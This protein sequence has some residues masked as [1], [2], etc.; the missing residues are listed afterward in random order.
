MSEPTRI[1]VRGERPYDVV[2]GEGL[3][4]EL[5]ALLAPQRAGR[6]RPPG[7]RCAR[8]A[9]A[10]RADLEAQRPRR[11]TPSRCPTARRRRTSRSRPTCWDVLGQVGFTRTDAVVSRRRRCDHRPRRL[12]RGDLAARRAGGARADDAARHGRR[13]RRRQDRHQHRAPARTSSARSTR[14]PA[15]LCDLTALETMPRHDYVA[16][17]AEVVKVGFTHDPRILEL[18]EQDPQGRADAGR[19]AHPRARRAGRGRQ[20]RGRRRRPHRAG[21]ARVPQLRPHARPRDREG[22]GLPLAARR[23]RVGRAGLRRRARPARRAARRR[24]R[25]PAPQ[26]AGVGRACRRRTPATGRGCARPW[27]ST[28]RRRGDRLRFVVLDAL[29]S[30]RILEDPDPGLLVAAYEEVRRDRGPEVYL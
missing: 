13:R 12:R 3:L 8:R 26:R 21:R 7:R 4:G 30:P 19:P 29:A 18:V 1:R 17:L 22:R 6:R 25:R 2:V 27:R 9:E 24:D 11:R 10:V 15:S 28:R 5:A 16:G 23:R 20:G 14:R